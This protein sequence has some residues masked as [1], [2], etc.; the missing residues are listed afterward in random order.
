MAVLLLTGA[1]P[2]SLYQAADGDLMEAVTFLT[3]DP[4]PEPVQSPAAAE[5]SAWEGSAVGKQ[6]PPGKGFTSAR[7]YGLVCLCELRGEL[8]ILPASGSSAALQPLLWCR[9]CQYWSLSSVLK[10]FG[11]D[12]SQLKS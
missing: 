9:F 10:M 2:L 5:P 12:T 6:R 4:A 7:P 3:E 1:S 8:S 11:G